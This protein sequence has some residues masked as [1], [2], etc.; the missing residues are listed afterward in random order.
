[1]VDFLNIKPIV[2]SVKQT[3]VTGLRY[4]INLLAHV[5]PGKYQN[6]ELYKLCMHER[7]VSRYTFPIKTIDGE[8][9]NKTVRR[10]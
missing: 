10:G 3:L 7:D 2:V 5:A 4:P 1:M 8:F 6:D 9:D